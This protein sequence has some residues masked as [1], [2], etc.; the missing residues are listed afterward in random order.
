MIQKSF[1]STPGMF[2]G[3]IAP[4][5]FQAACV[6]AGHWTAGRPGFARTD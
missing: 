5:V 1:Q 2:L 3:V 4:A 6:F